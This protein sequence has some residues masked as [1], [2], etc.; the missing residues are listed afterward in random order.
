MEEKKQVSV[1]AVNEIEQGWIGR[2]RALKPLLE[3]AAPRIDS[4]CAL[5][6]DIL[7]AMFGSRM[8]RML[9]PHTFGGAELEPATFFQAVSEIAAGDASAAWCVA[10]S[11]GCSMSAAYMDPA[12]A[13]KV[14]GDSR[15]AVAWGYSMGPHC[16]ATP[17]KG[18]WHV[19][20][21]WGFGSGNRHATWVGAHCNRTDEAGEILMDPD[22]RPLERTMLI[23]RASITIKE[24]SW[25]VVGLRG[26]GSDTYSVKDLFVP[27]EY[28]VIARA[29]ARDHHLPEGAEP[30]LEPERREHG[31]L[32]RFSPMNVYEA[33][34]AAVGL[35][36][37]RGALDAFIA[38]AQKKTPTGTGNPLRDDSWIQTRIALSE[39]RLASASA[40]IVAILRE[41][42]GE[43]A[44]G[45]PT[46]ELRVKLRLASTYAIHEAREVVH[47]SYA[48]AGATA[49]FEGNPFER[50]L[51]DI[52]AVSQQIQANFAHLQSV[53][54]YYLGMK[55]G[56]R[57]I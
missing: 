40:W 47:A 14:F 33:G 44:A 20:G 6:T 31:P 30:E 22:G 21:T 10:Q 56:L 3:A 15:A 57:Y 38:L 25:H 42:W 45:R 46:F 28:S 49:I 39:A 29:T 55:P 24:D 34:F 54:Q 48:D 13:H 26:T 4:A 32:Y 53:G 1:A 23:P 9:L 36:V 5:P 17:V 35:G 41:L 8:F 37:A 12:A 7:D 2:A 51:R 16:R 50:R 43:C 19:N 52:N 18:G 11:S 27:G